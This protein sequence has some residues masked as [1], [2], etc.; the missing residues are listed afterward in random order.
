MPEGAF[1]AVLVTKGRKTGKPH[2]VEL[3][4]VSYN[5]RVYF[6]RRNENAD[7]LKNALANSFVSVE[8][9]GK[10]HPGTASLVTDDSLARKISELKY[11]GEERAQDVRIV[12]QVQLTN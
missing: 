4:A 7:W 12:L 8:F 2:S 3:R 9:D 11:P 6:S 5:N 10:S 1:R